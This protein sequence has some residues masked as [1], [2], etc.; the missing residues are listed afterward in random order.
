MPV[1]RLYFLF[2]K[3]C[4]GVCLC[5]KLL[6]S[7]ST[8]CDHVNY[9]QPGFPVHGILQTRILKWVT[10]TFSKGSSPSRDQ[11]GSPALQDRFFTF[12]ATKE[13]HSCVSIFQIIEL[14]ILFA[15]NFTHWW[16]NHE[17]MTYIS[18]CLCVSSDEIPW[19]VPV[20]DDDL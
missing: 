14:R 12:W 18:L 2:Y 16:W 1:K 11:N 13:A 17:S 20:A 7:C 19:L 9:R 5:A 4:V 6:L 8:L 3:L 10:M 15:F